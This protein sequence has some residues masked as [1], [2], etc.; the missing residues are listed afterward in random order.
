MWGCPYQYPVYPNIAYP[1]P[2]PTAQTDIIKSVPLS[3]VFWEYY[4]I[5]QIGNLA[6]Y[7]CYMVHIDDGEN[8]TPAMLREYNGLGRIEYKHT[9]D[10]TCGILTQPSYFDVKGHEC[11]EANAVVCIMPDGEVIWL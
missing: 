6:P 5:N 8:W 4:N 3:K 2:Q 9:K 11:D 1:M 10:G 7:E